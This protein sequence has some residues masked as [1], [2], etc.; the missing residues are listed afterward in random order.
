MSA[1]SRSSPAIW[2]ALIGFDWL[3][4]VTLIFLVKTSVRGRTA[5]NGR[6]FS[7]FA[8]IFSKLCGRLEILSLCAFVLV[9]AVGGL[10]LTR[11]GEGALLGF[12]RVWKVQ[13]SSCRYLSYL[14]CW[15]SFGGAYSP[16][17]QSAG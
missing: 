7:S 5:T 2:G 12:L 1:Y 4:L 16:P 14:E 9:V 6:T 3:L 17:P 11:Q 13:I 8:A 10:P 15:V